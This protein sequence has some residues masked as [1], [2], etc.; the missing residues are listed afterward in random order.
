MQGLGAHRGKIGQIDP[1]QLAG[2][3]VGRIVGQVMHPF[4]HRVDGDDEPP[5]R[6]AVEESGVVAQLQAARSGQ[7]RKKASDPAELTEPLARHPR[8]P[9]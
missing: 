5:P 1:Q 3:E 7:R 2:D 8:A 4:D 6:C 9:A